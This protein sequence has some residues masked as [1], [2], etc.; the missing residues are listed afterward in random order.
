MA[1]SCMLSGQPCLVE[2]L[3]SMGGD[4]YPLIC[5]CAFAL[6]YMLCM[7]AWSDVLNPYLCRTA[8]RYS[9]DTLSNAPLKSRDMTHSGLLVFLAYAI[10]SCNVA[11]ASNTNW[12]WCPHYWFFWRRSDSQGLSRAVVILVSSL[13]SVFIKVSSL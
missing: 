4:R 7:W 3:T 10:A 13:N 2:L 1:Y 12:P 11:R 5:M 8:N 9:C 6:W